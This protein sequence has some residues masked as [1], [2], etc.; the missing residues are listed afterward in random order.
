M[1]LW[2]VSS[3][4][5]AIAMNRQGHFELWKIGL[6]LLLFAACVWLSYIWARK[7]QLIPQI[8]RRYFQLGKIA[9]GFGLMF[10][11]GMISALIMALTGTNGTENQEIIDNIGKVLPPLVFVIM[12]TSAGFFEELIFRVSLFELLFTNW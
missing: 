11:V 12:T 10:A 2:Q 7:Y 3:A 5:P 6:F 4:L 9:G 1:V 8:N